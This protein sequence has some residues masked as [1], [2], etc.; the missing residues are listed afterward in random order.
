M[1]RLVIELR[2]NRDLFIYAD[3]D[4]EIDVVDWQSVRE[5]AED[6][7]NWDKRTPIEE[8]KRELLHKTTGLKQIYP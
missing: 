2:E 1:T 4:V 3:G 6:L 8:A 7:P 5:D